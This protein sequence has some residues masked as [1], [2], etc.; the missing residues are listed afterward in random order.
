ME[1][2]ACKRGK[3]TLCNN[4]GFFW[5]KRLDKW[6]DSGIIV[7]ERGGQLN[8]KGEQSENV[9]FDLDMPAPDHSL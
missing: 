2:Q 3:R 6:P 7:L 5:L 1:L 9:G 8:L 4:F